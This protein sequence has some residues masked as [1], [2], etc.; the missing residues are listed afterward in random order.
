MTNPAARLLALLLGHEAR[1]T[2]EQWSEV[3]AMDNL[4][5]ICGVAPRNPLANV[6]QSCSDKSDRLIE[7]LVEQTREQLISERQIAPP[8]PACEAAA[9]ERD[10]AYEDS[11]QMQQRL[12]RLIDANPNAEAHLDRIDLLEAQLRA[13][14][15]Q[16]EQVSRDKAAAVGAA[17][18]ERDD[19]R[20]QIEALANEMETAERGVRLQYWIISLRKIAE[21]MGTRRPNERRG[22]RRD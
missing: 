14:R 16:V 18:R 5:A 6:C 3:R 21:K 12:Q 9:R 1:I 15:A 13:V 22:R 2:S 11:R 17:K 8:C 4:C 19:L 10:A 20:A 7:L